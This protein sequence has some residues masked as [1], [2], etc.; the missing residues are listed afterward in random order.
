MVHKRI[1]YNLVPPV[2]IVEGDIFE[3]CNLMQKYP[4]THICPGISGLIFRQCNLSNCDLPLDAVIQDC[5]QV[6]RH[7][8]R[9]SNLHPAWGIEPVCPVNC[10]HVVDSDTVMIDGVSATVN[11][12]YLDQEVA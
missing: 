6:G 11:Y 3:D 9:C 2:G 1:N 5:G 7:K 12:F 8:S 4:H 10:S